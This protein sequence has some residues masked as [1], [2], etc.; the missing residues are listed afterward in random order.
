MT[1]AELAKHDGRDKSRATLV[2]SCGYIFEHE[3]FISAFR[4]R[5]ITHRNAL[6]RRGVN[7]DANDDA[8][9]MARLSDL[10]ADEREYAC[11]TAT[12]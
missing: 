1:R 9:V 3:P 12:C 10:S 2:S 8:T 5:D 4:G 7:L 6:H 11:A